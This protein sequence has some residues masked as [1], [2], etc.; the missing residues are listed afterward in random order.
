[1][2]I[3]MRLYIQYIFIFGNDIIMKHCYQN[4]LSKQTRHN[5]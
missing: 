2:Q 4:V 1:M 5:T 3:I